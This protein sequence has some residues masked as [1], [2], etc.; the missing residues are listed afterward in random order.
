MKV[1]SKQKMAICYEGLTIE[2]AFEADL[3]VNDRSIIELKS[4]ELL[5]NIRKKQ[6]LTY[7]QLTNLRLG[8]L[9]NF[10][11]VLIKDGMVRV[12]IELPDTN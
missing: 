10:N 4:V 12:V 7:L 2:N 6:L 9:I 11:V 1:L 5:T 3:A 8:L